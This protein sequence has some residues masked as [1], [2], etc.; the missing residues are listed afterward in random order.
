ME[1][2]TVILGP[3]VVDFGVCEDRPVVFIKG[4]TLLAKS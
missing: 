4:V 2:R 1:I 3:L